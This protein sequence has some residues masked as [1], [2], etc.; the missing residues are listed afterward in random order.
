MP[1]LGFQPAASLLTSLGDFEEKV[2]TLFDQ[3][4]L[5]Q[6][7]QRLTQV[8]GAVLRRLGQLQTADEEPA[9]GLERPD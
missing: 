9:A 2:K 3:E 4:E 8:N 6:L 1:R 7:S 5:E